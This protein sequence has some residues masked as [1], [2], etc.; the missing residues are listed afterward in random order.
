MA[1]GPGGN[2]F[3]RVLCYVLNEILVQVLAN[4]RTF[5]RFAVRTNKSLEN[6]SS[7]AKEVRE[8]LSEQ[9]RNSRGNDDHFRQ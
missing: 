3:G 8:E 9:W 1:C 5:Q 7:K 2:L 4:N 6:L